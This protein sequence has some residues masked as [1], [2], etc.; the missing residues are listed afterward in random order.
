MKKN[1]LCLF[2]LIG[3]AG[4]MS[5]QKVTVTDV[6]AVP[7]ETVK[8]TLKF[9]CPAG[10]Y[11]GMQISLNF[12]SSDFTVLMPYKI[13][14]G[15]EN[16]E[17]IS[18]ITGWKGLLKYSVDGGTVKYSA[19]GD[20]KF[21]SSTINVEFTVGDKVTVVEHKVTISGQLE[22]PGVDDAPIN[23]TLIVNVVAAHLVTLS[24]DATEAPKAATAVNVKV[25]RAIAANTW[26]TL[27]LPFAMTE[28]QVK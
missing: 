21:S 27:C 1:I 5:A 7:G 22:G 17:E 12:P 3:M 2:A 6:E 28:I 13:N 15:E 19:A 8:A 26:S 23:G 16:E 14:E 10:T 18:A 25:E 24:E 20:S 4:A 9:E 11:T